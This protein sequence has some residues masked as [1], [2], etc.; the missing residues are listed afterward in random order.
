MILLQAIK[1]YDMGTLALLPVRRI[2]IAIKNTMPQPG[3][4]PHPL[5]PVASTLTT[6]PPRTNILFKCKLE[7]YA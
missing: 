6:T 3:L 4:T 5:G 2:F 7:K 1:S